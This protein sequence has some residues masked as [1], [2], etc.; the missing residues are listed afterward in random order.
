MVLSLKANF[1]TSF[2]AAVLDEE[3]TVEVGANIFEKVNAFDRGTAIVPVAEGFGG[4]GS[5]E[6]AGAEGS[7][8]AA[9]AGC[10]VESRP[11]GLE[12]AVDEAALTCRNCGSEAKVD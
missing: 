10:P 6:K 12:E 8:D 4:A 1:C 5:N 7:R 9:A 11:E 3:G 2:D